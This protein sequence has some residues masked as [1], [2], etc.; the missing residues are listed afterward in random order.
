MGGF[1]APHISH[2]CAKAL[3]KQKVLTA[4]FLMAKKLTTNFLYG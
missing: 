4:I 3:N 2:L 1:L